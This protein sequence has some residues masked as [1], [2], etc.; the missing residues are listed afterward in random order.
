MD[1]L[2]NYMDEICAWL[3]RTAGWI[4]RGD[5]P[6]IPWAGWSSGYLH[7]PPAPHLEFVYIQKGGIPDARVGNAAVNYQQGHVTINNIHFGAYGQG[8][9]PNTRAWCFFLNV[10]GA[11]EMAELSREPMVVQMP[12]RDTTTFEALCDRLTQ[13]SRFPGI[14]NPQYPSGPPAYEPDT[15]HHLG[16]SS[17]LRLKAVVLDLLSFLLEEAGVGA[18]ARHEMPPAIRLAMNYMDHHYTRADITLPQLARA[19]HLSPDHF[20]R[21]F[22]N[23]M[24]LSPLQHV[25]RLRVQ[26]SCFLLTHSPLTI[27]Q[28]AGE[29]GFR[30]PLH[31]SRVFRREMGR[32]PRQFREQRGGAR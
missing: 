3:E 2:C 28:V 7:N 18:H 26:R 9:I 19:A 17:R 20:G 11:P 4:D 16:S 21:L 6:V 13:R 22:R 23:V 27:A 30:D 5:L 10:D 15:M 29:V 8:C 24:G 31:F 25:R 1:E 14:Q 32:S 12:V